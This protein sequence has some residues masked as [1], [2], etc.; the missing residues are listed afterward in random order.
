M[1]QRQQVRRALRDRDRAEAA[2][3]FGR[4]IRL[5]TAAQLIDGQIAQP[6]AEAWLHRRQVGKATAPLVIVDDPAFTDAGK[7]CPECNGKGRA[8][9]Y[10][11][12]SSRYCP[13][14]DYDEAD[15]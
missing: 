15:Q 6:V 5:T 9:H 13:A 8:P 12:Q 7:T 10:P 1:S 14:C 3:A 2:A 4:R 11:E